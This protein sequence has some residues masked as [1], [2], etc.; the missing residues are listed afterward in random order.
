MVGYLHMVESK[1]RK[2]PVPKLKMIHFAEI[3]KRFNPRLNAF[4][5]L[6]GDPI[7][8]KVTPNLHQRHDEKEKKTV[9]VMMMG[10]RRGSST[11]S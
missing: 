11:G 10:A 3:Q 6:E 4:K 9:V 1:H 5:Q 2:T 8:H 7:T